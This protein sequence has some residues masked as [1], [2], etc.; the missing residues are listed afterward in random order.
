M[1]AQLF[2]VTLLVH[3]P[4]PLTVRTCRCGFPLDSLG[5]HRAACARAGVLR[6]R[7]WALESVA[8]RICREGGGRVTTNV[9]LRDLD[10]A[11]PRCGIVQESGP[12]FVMFLSALHGS[13]TLELWCGGGL[14]Y[15]LISK[16]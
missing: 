10:L 15:R 13:R 8:G 7:G 9:L 2:R 3:Q 11:R 1:E 5:H 12:K 4:V 14:A 6:K 16:G